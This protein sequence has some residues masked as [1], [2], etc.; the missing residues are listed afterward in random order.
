MP[1]LD[2]F[3]DTLAAIRAALADEDFAR[4][5]AL[6]GEHDA[7]VRR[8]VAERG[9]GDGSREAI[10]SLLAAQSALLHE[11]LAA[12]E[13]AAERMGRTQRAGAAARAYLDTRARLDSDAA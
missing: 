1:P 3:G 11:L 7:H 4:A 2:D 9:D 12:R 5:Q 6:M 10:E 13:R 8:W